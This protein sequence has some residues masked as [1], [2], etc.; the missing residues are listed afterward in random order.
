P[1]VEAADHTTTG[2]RL[3]DRVLQCLR[4]PLGDAGGHAVLV[5]LTT[6]CSIHA[7]AVVLEF[8]LEVD[9]AV[10]ARAEGPEA[11]LAALVPNDVGL[12]LTKDR[13]DLQVTRAAHAGRGS[14]DCNLHLLFT[15]DTQL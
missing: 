8:T 12:R 7:G 3:N 5:I 14:I 6:D 11:H 13:F 4:V 2:S 10:V 15:T 9:P 1:F